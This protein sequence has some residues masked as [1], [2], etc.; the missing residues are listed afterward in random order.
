VALNAILSESQVMACSGNL[1]RGVPEYANRNGLWACAF[2]SFSD[3]KIRLARRSN[4]NTL[5]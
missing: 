2:H 4:K 3:D 1:F 5:R